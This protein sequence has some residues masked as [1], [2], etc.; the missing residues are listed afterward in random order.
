L[1]KSQHVIERSIYPELVNLLKKIGYTD[2]LG[3]SKVGKNR[4]YTDI[5]FSHKSEKY[6]VEIK[7]GELVNDAALQMSTIN[8]S[9][10]YA[11]EK[12]IENII[13]LVYPKDL[14][15]HIY[16]DNEWFTKECTTK[17]IRCIKF[18]KEGGWESSISKPNDFFK[19]L[20]RIT[21]QEQ[22]Q[23][24]A[25]NFI[26]KELQ[27]II[28]DLNQVNNYANKTKLIEEV[29]D[30]LK[31]FIG[32]G[33]AEKEEKI[34]EELVNLSTYLLFNQL[35]FY[36]IYRI[37]VKENNLKPLKPIEKIKELQEYF[38]AIEIKGFSAIY[39]S[40]ILNH[41]KDD[42]KVIDIINDAIESLQSLRPEIITHDIAGIFFHKLIP[43]EIRKV[44]ATFYTVPNAADLLAGLTVKKYNDT[45][46]DPA[47][48]SGTLLVSSY[49]IKQK[50]YSKSFGNFSLNKAHKEFLENEI[51]G[52]DIMPFA[53][54]LSAMN[55]TLQNIEQNTDNV[56]I[57]SG[58][59]LDL[60][61]HFISESFS[62]GKGVEVTKYE[63][64][65]QN[66]ITQ[67]MKKIP[68]L[69]TPIITQN[70]QG[71]LSMD[72]EGTPFKITKQDIVIMNPPFSDI[73]KIAKTSPEMLEKL[74]KNLIIS[75]VV[76]NQVNLWG[77]FL[78]LSELVLKENGR[79]SAIIPIS[80]GV[81]GATEKIRTHFLK[82]FTVKFIIKPS[83]E[84]RAF[85]QNAWLKDIMLIADKKIPNLTDKSAIVILK[86]S[87]KNSD[88]E[89]ITKV[90]EKLKRTISNYEIGYHEETEDYSINIISAKEI[91][92]NAS[93]LMPFFVDPQIIEFV[94]K[95]RKDGKKNLRKITNKDM[96]E[97]YHLSPVGTSNVMCITNPLDPSRTKQGTFLVLEEKRN[98]KIVVKIKNTELKYEIPITK[99]KN[100]LR[101]LTGVKKFNLEELDYTITSQFPKFDEVVKLSKWN[102]EKHG[103]F[104]WANH[105]IKLEKAE[106]FVYIPCVFRPDSKNT[107]NFVF[108]AQKKIHASHAFKALKCKNQQEGKYQ[109]LLLN[110]SF[111]IAL[112]LMYR[113]QATGGKTNIHEHAFN[114][115]DIFDISKLTDEQKSKLDKVF[116]E[117]KNTEFP[118][119]K[120]QFELND[121]DR[122]TL[123]LAVLEVFGIDFK[124]GSRILDKIYKIF[125]DEFTVD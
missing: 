95:I 35:L 125:P 104:N 115:F 30:K 5:T 48:G 25:L 55:L 111:G 94:E 10:R 63:T 109:T 105:N 124:K 8:Q 67:Y 59:S 58:D 88:D 80:F 50:L 92:D 40:K 101:T 36:R 61:N 99:T 90:V 70:T 69:D 86:F 96:H 41:L 74:K 2:V 24:P 73:E 78:A 64:T 71:A 91:S 4:N 102:E 47:C 117:I 110:S 16:I 112:L 38:D 65:T 3:E 81:G 21:N 106:E 14:L 22:F 53:G 29:V 45:V 54:H 18:T 42:Q 20:K 84:D 6:F 26:V 33:G 121:K 82:K 103:K 79:V 120:E 72:G 108:Y 37:R 76:G 66:P 77:Y 113:S 83:N 23:K 13:I 57:G 11:K 116:E 52:Y 31:V 89:K 60:A 9:Y 107:H 51:T 114:N 44:L 62:K 85:S 49:K 43:F 46:F 1:S 34:K 7:F 32:I 122:R 56:R 123:D 19:I 100:F 68:N 98:D 93:N 39:S 27:M 17:D 75:D 28:K 87:I 119:L 15:G 97:G 118:S 12:G